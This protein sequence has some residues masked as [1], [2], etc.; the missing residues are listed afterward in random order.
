[1]KELIKKYLM[2]S[3]NTKRIL[4]KKIVLMEEQIETMIENAKEREI[5]K[6]ELSKKASNMQKKALELKKELAMMTMEN[7]TNKEIIKTLTKKV[8][9]YERR[10]EK[11]K[12]NNNAKKR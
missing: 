5:A 6:E 3:I 4:R 2:D 12:E 10:E 1:M 8:E 7:N 11:R 9:K